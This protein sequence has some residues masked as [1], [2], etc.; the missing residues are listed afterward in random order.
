M[1][2]D[3]DVVPAP[4]S[5]SSLSIQVSSE[6]PPSGQTPA[7]GAPKR[8][9]NAKTRKRKLAHLDLRWSLGDF[10]LCGK[11]NFQAILSFP[12]NGHVGKFLPFSLVLIRAASQAQT[13][14]NSISE[15]N[16]E[17]NVNNV[18]EPR[19]C[20]KSNMHKPV[21]TL[22]KL[23]TE[24]DAHSNFMKSESDNNA[25]DAGGDFFLELLPD[26]TA[27]MVSGRKKNV[28]RLPCGGS[29]V[30]S[31][32]L[33][34]LVGGYLPVPRFRLFSSRNVI[35]DDVSRT[36]KNLVHTSNILCHVSSKDILVYSAETQT[37]C[38]AVEGAMTA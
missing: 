32:K 7:I 38:M 8:Q 28:F 17:K 5:S 4:L 26:E 27:W 21:R 24:P 37:T 13:A 34:P 35:N 25:P 23:L 31:C 9:L 20:G 29:H 33:L 1:A 16:F 3:G 6:G 18:L 2:G 14:P 12:A 11:Q 19:L 36:T 30:F 15:E 22:C 10:E